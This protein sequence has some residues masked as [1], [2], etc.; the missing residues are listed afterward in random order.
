MLQKGKLLEAEKACILRV[1]WAYYRVRVRVRVRTAAVTHRNMWDVR[2]G[3]IGRV[4]YCNT[5][6][7]CGRDGNFVEFFQALQTSFIL[8]Q[9]STNSVTPKY[10]TCVARDTE[11]KSPQFSVQKTLECM[12]LF[13]HGSLNF[14]VGYPGAL[15]TRICHSH[16][17]QLSKSSG[18]TQVRNS[19]LHTPG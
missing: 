12:R 9:T 6:Y 7:S 8:L 15:F 16:P 3:S 10:S 11:E 1:Q 17:S 2:G 13:F 18:N 4:E 5:A 14:F 19:A